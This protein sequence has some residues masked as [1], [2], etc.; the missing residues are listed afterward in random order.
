MLK[1]N[2]QNV[3]CFK[4]QELLRY[5]CNLLD[6][7]SDIFELKY[8]RISDFENFKMKLKFLFRL[9]KYLFLNFH[10]YNINRFLDNSMPHMGYNNKSEIL[11]QIYQMMRNNKN[12]KN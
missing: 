4:I 11:S 12:N 6:F 5:K 1:I 7:E 3:I 2:I 9:F 8:E 10:L